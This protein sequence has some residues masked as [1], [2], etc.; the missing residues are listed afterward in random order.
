[1]VRRRKRTWEKESLS[2][3][4]LVNFSRRMLSFAK[5]ARDLGEAAGLPRGTL[6]DLATILLDIEEGV[7]DATGVELTRKVQDYL[8]RVIPPSLRGETIGGR[9]LR[10]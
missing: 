8:A 6:R 2:F 5:E 7:R 4:D 1:M 3:G 10:C 9:G